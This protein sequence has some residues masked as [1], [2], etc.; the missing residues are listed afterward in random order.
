LTTGFSRMSA[1]RRIPHQQAE[2]PL[3][4]PKATTGIEPV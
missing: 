2:I 1:Y 3:F 4:K